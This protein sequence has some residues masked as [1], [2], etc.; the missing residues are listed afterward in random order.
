MTSDFSTNRV[1]DFRV[2]EKDQR[3][4]QSI[5]WKL[6]SAFY[7]KTGITAW[8]HGYI[9]HYITN[10]PNIA[11]AYARIVEGYLLDQA[12]VDHDQPIYILELGAGPGRFA[13]QFL[14]RFLPAVQNSHLRDIRFIYLITDQAESN[15][16]FWK[17]H[18][19]FKP[20]LE[21]GQLDM[22]CFNPLQDREI[23]LVCSGKKLSAADITNPLIV[24]ANYFLDS[25]PS[26]LFSIHEGLLCEELL[27]LTGKDPQLAPTDPSIVPSLEACFHP[28]FSSTPYYHDLDFDQVL[29]SYI[30]LL[31][32]SYLLFPIGALHCLRFLQQLSN[33]QMLF[34]TADKGEYQLEALRSPSE[35]EISR[36]GSGISMM[37]NFHALNGFLQQQGGQVAQSKHRE[38]GL[39]FSAFMTGETPTNALET[40]WAFRESI[41][42]DSPDDFFMLKKAFEPHYASSTLEQLLAF[43]NLSGDD[44][45]IFRDMYPFLLELAKTADVRQQ[46][47]LYDA[48]CR[49]WKMFYPIGEPINLQIPLAKMFIFLSHSAEALEC[50]R[51]SQFFYGPNDEVNLLIEQISQYAS[52]F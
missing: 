33:G 34:L 39:V 3:L 45:Q 43:L 51:S 26:D 38:E 31:N 13:Y 28:R 32:E 16:N 11:A 29:Q 27:T 49:V 1:S 40:S 12:Q 46:E 10:N 24:L 18:P 47:E 48:T 41:E 7:Q 42:E 37:V 52:E 6:E 35:P 36:H 17:S 9:P 14:Q 4:S 2:I 30:P 22:A 23:H 25:L 15:V 44:P 50:L 8:N 5:L 19:R 21:S 20:Y